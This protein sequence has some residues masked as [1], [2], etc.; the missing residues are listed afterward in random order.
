MTE[1]RRASTAG[2]VAYGE[3]PELTRGLRAL[4][5]PRHSGAHQR[6]GLS[7]RLH[8]QFFA[9]LVDARRRAAESRT[10]DATIRAFDATHLQHE[11]DRLLERIVAEWPDER[12]PARRALRTRL[13]E[14]VE[15]YETALEQLRDRGSPALSDAGADADTDA[16]TRRL[17]AWRDWTAQL[18]STFQAADRAWM[19]LRTVLDRL[20]DPDQ[21]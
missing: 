20:P 19:A 16:D 13:H 10:P 4:G 17:Q 7:S 3:L 21:R 6:P 15:D 2:D 1:H 18:V 8:A 14:R 12:A 9:P 5:S 11:L